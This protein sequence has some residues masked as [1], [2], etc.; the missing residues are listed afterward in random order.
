LSNAA[1]YIIPRHPPICPAP[2]DVLWLRAAL[3]WAILPA[4]T[5]ETDAYGR[6]CCSCGRPSCPSPGKHPNCSFKHHTGPL[7][8]EDLRMY[9]AGRAGKNSCVLTGARSGILVA[10][11]D[12]R[13]DGT[14]DALWEL[15][16]L[17]ETV[18]ALSGGGGWHVYAAGPPEGLPSVD[19]YAT[20]IEVKAEGK[21]V[22]LPPSLHASGRRYRWQPGH[23]PW[24]V[25]VAPLP[26]PTL[27]SLA[28]LAAQRPA[29]AERPPT[30][31][32]AGESVRLDGPPLTPAQLR[33]ARRQ[34]RAAVKTAI[35]RV[36]DE[37]WGRHD[38]GKTL[39]SRLVN[40]WLPNDEVDAYALRFQKVVR[41]G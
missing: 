20:G 32:G 23:E 40:L 30:V 11:V 21:L 29:Q 28:S 13:H 34:A 35:H 41:W 39:S 6:V 5:P 25:G 1:E 3:G 12:P 7:P 18:I 8:L 2:P 27:A 22:I 4:E 17:Q 38:A 33:W 16:W 15:G 26:P 14:L 24:V 37:G 10:D 31:V 9:F 36:R 19:S